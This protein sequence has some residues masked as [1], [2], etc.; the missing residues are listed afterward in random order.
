M[1]SILIFFSTIVLSFRDVFHS[2]EGGAVIFALAVFF[3]NISFIN[4]AKDNIFISMVL[5]REFQ[6][7]I[8]KQQKK[9]EVSAETKFLMNKG[10]VPSANTSVFISKMIFCLLFA[11]S[12]QTS[13]IA[14][15]STG[16]FNV[17]FSYSILKIFTQKAEINIYFALIV[18]TAVVLQGVHNALLDNNAVVERRGFTLLNMLVV[19]LSCI[20]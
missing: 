1:N 14:E 18:I 3:I 5:E 2:M 8:K 6:D 20:L 15:V 9:R 7:Y 4:R 16:I 11:Y 13:Y 12:C 19:G 10:Y 17:E